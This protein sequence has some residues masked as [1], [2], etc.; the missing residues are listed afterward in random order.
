VLFDFYLALNNN[1]YICQVESH[2]IVICP[3]F[4]CRNGDFTWFSVIKHI[5]LSLFPLAEGAEVNAILF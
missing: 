4:A 1:I 2:E 3:P 5:Y